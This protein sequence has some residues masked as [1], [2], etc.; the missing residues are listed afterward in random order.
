MA[1]SKNTIKTLIFQ[2]YRGGGGPTFSQWGG[3]PIAY[4]YRTC[5][6]PGRGSRSA[7][8]L[9]QFNLTFWKTVCLKEIFSYSQNDSIFLHT[10]NCNFKIRRKFGG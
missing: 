6:F 3:G 7:H 9:V 10:V 4:S 2:D 8:A 1:I 5:D